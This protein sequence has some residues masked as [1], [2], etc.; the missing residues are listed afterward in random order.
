[1]KLRCNNSILMA[2]AVL[3]LLIAFIRP[4][5]AGQ[6]TFERQYQYRAGDMDSLISCR[7][8]ALEQV[9]R[10]LLEEL[11]V[12]LE[13]NT[14][15]KN[16]QLTK[17]KVTVLTAGIVSTK[18]L[19]EK[20]DGK[21][22]YLRARII[23]DPDDVVKKLDALRK[24]RH[25]SDEMWAA[26]QVY[27]SAHLALRAGQI[28]EA[29]RLLRKVVAE[30]PRTDIAQT[31][32]GQ[33]EKLQEIK[34]FNSHQLDNMAQTEIR[35]FRTI[36]EAYFADYCKWPASLDD[37]GRA[38]GGMQVAPGVKVMYAS[39]IL[40]S[41]E[42]RFTLYAYH[43]SGQKVFVSNSSDGRIDEVEKASGIL[44]S[45]KTDYRVEEKS[46]FMTILKKK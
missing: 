1:M 34:K 25:K 39:E 41:R 22:Y 27:D 23:A 5:S 35:K 2:I 28:T 33:I 46:E 24:D 8:I 30:Y 20:W 31:S 17:D 4:A 37:M 40:P 19:D 21:T 15:V 38:A 32:A 42:S 10:L 45:L 29:E 26:I 7:I 12:Y 6:V 11:G 3:V 18:I 36:L 44:S 43:E 13:T 16:F 9:K 14:E